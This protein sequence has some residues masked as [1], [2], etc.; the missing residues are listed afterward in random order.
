MITVAISTMSRNLNSL[1][2]RVLDFTKINCS[3]NFLI[4]SQDEIINEKYT[5]NDRVVVI[6]SDTIGLSKSRNIAIDSINYGWIW[7]QDDD[8]EINFEALDEV[9]ATLKRENPDVFF[10]KIGSLESKTQFYKNY[11]HYMKHSY[12]N[13]LKVSSI[14]IIVKKSFVE[15]YALKFDEK[16]GLGTNLPCCEENKFVF[17]CFKYT[18]NITYFHGVACY[19]TTI[20]CNRHINYIK[21]LRAKGYL[22]ANIPL[23]ISFLLFF[24]WSFKFSKVSGFSPLV[25]LKLLAQGYFL[26]RLG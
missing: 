17:D 2:V 15:R 3:I 26:K 23:F 16:L 5:L 14:E 7:F 13:F 25:C 4:I 11:K 20:L 21:N 24:R 10:I 22:L 1:L 9:R 6:K 12:L 18:K 8:I 19:H